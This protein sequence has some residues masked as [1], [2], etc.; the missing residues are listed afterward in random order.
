MSGKSVMLLCFVFSTLAMIPATAH[1]FA[2]PNK[3]KMSGADFLVAQK[4]YFGWA[5]FGIFEA[6]AIVSFLA[7]AFFSR[8]QREIL[9]LSLFALGCVIFANVLF[10][11][12][13]FPANQRTENWTSL[14]VNWESLRR[15]WEYSHAVRA[16]LL[17]SALFSTYLAAQWQ[18]KA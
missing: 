12:F 16:V 2:L 5:L 11:I 13:N 10:W 3:M 15:R 6:T 9:A 1:L 7:L 8:Q 18:A 14:P 4:I 17:F